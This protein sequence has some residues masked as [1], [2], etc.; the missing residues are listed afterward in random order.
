MKTRNGFVSNS[1]S[2]S[3]LIMGVKIRNDSA[4]QNN[5]IENGQ[6]NEENAGADLGCEIY[7]TS[8]GFSDELCIYQDEYSDDIYLGYTI[9]LESLQVIDPKV[10]NDKLDA[11]KEIMDRLDGMTDD[12]NPYVTYIYKYE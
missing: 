4:D 5:W 10:I 8:S 1:S 11:M 6:I 7:Y 2:S 12:I 3:F 9:G